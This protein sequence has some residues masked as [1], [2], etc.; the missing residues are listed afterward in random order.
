MEC[1]MSRMLVWEMWAVYEMLLVRKGVDC[2]C[3]I[4]DG[5]LVRWCLE[6]FDASMRAGS[7]S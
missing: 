6:R 4:H 1:T 5:W 7:S 2:G 3:V